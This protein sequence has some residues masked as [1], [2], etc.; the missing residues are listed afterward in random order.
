MGSSRARAL[1]LTAPFR[2][3]IRTSHL[4][5]DGEPLVGGTFEFGILNDEYV[6][7]RGAAEAQGPRSK[8]RKMLPCEHADGRY[9]LVER[10]SACLCRRA[11]G[12][13]YR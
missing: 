6:I 8:H 9:R 2:R 1:H 5:R 3:I 12:F 4:W 10:F 7:R 11:H 13:R